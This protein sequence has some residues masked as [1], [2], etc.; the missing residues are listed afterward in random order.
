MG[1]MADYLLDQMWDDPFAEE[2]R[3]DGDGPAQS[4]KVCRNCKTGGLHWEKIDKNWR[5]FGADDKIHVCAVR[6]LVQIEAKP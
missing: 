1:D 4:A 6:P 5:L 2:E 3:E